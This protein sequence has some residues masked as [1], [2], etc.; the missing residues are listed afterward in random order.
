MEDKQIIQKLLEMSRGYDIE[1]FKNININETHSAFDG[2]PKKHPYDEKLLFLIPD[3][4]SELGEFYEFSIDS[5]GNIEDLGSISSEDGE[6]V[7]RVRIWVKK[8]AIAIKSI[9][10]KIE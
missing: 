9:P 10:F 3:P 8:G 2:T 6:T 4:Y 7:Y 5:I 1:K